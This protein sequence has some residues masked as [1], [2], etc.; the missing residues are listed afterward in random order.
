[1]LI[2]NRYY[3]SACILVGRWCFKSW[4]FSCHIWPIMIYDNRKK[5]LWMINACHAPYSL[6]ILFVFWMLLWMMVVV[7]LLSYPVSDAN[8]AHL[9]SFFGGDIYR[10]LDSSNLDK[11]TMDFPKFTLRITS[12]VW[13]N[14]RNKRQWIYDNDHGRNVM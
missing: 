10:T 14:C 1:M 4:F 11:L 13:K 2:H 8:F 9:M 7:V 6:I 12:C 5:S 3:I